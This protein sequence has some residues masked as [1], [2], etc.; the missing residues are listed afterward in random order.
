MVSVI[1]NVCVVVVIHRH[2]CVR[3]FGNPSHPRIHLYKKDLLTHFDALLPGRAADAPTTFPQVGV[4]DF[5]SQEEGERTIITVT[6]SSNSDS[7]SCM[8]VYG[9]VQWCEVVY[10]GVWWCMT[11][12]AI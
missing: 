8:V 2:H 7:S 5:T 10:S 3:L 1:C 12:V 9:G 6:S 11:I 4:R